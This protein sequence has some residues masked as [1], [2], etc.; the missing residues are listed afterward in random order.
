MPRNLPKK[1]KQNLQT[2]CREKQKSLKQD[3]PSVRSLNNCTELFDNL[4]D[5][6]EQP[7]DFGMF[8]RNDIRMNIIRNEH[9]KDL[10]PWLWKI[11]EPYFDRTQLEPG[12]LNYLKS[13]R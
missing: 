12:P 13:L 9:W 10:N 7:G 1:V 2:M 5:E 8:L 6:L 11:V 4:I 3:M